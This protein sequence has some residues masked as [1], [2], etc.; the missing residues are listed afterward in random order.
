MRLQGK[1]GVGRFWEW[2]GWSL[3]AYFCLETLVSCLCT[4][5]WPTRACVWNLAH[6][7]RRLPTTNWPIRA[8]LLSMPY[9]TGAAESVLKCGS[10]GPCI[11]GSWPLPCAFLSLCSRSAFPQGSFQS[12]WLHSQRFVANES[13]I[14]HRQNEDT[15]WR[16]DCVLRFYRPWQ[17]AATLLRAVRK[18]EMCL[19][20]F[21]N[22]FGVQGTKCVC[23]TNF[24][25]V[26]KPVIIWESWSFCQALFATEL[27]RLKA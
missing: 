21:R 17:N 8:L 22:I 13:R 19:K 20:I 26:P 7:F 16:Q 27:L 15:L 6:R 1:F 9:I 4:G 18:Q 25:L 14:R 5:R 10:S 12:W 23:A 11:S 3:N 2:K 24:A